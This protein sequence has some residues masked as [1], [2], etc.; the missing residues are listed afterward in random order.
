MLIKK[1]D[2]VLFIIFLLLIFSLINSIFILSGQ[3]LR[4]DEAQSIWASVKSIPAILLYVAQDVHVPLYELILHFWIQIF[5]ANILYA[6]I[7]SFIFFLGSLPFLYLITK[8]VINRNAAVLTVFLFSLS[9]FISWYTF[10]ARMYTLFTFLV[11]ASH[12]FFLQLLNSN[13]KKGSLGYFFATLAG[14]YTHYFFFLLLLTQ[15]LYLI[16]H[17]YEKFRETNNFKLFFQYYSG[18]LSGFLSPIFLAVFLFTP[19]IIYFIMLGSASNTQPFILPPSSITLFQTMVN[20]FFGL[21]DPVIQAVLVSLWPLA[22]VPLFF[23]FSKREKKIRFKYLAYFLTSSFL[24]IILVFIISFI[25]PI[26]LSRYLILV[27]P[28]LFMLF[29]WIL[30]NISFRASR[31]IIIIVA[32]V[33]FCSVLYQ[34]Q[35]AGTPVKEN[36]KAV[37]DYLNK[38]AQ[39]GDIIAVSPPFTVYPLMYYYTGHTRMTSI[40]EW[41]LYKIG[42]IQ[43]FTTA[44]MV[45]QINSYKSVDRNIYIVF[46]YDQ[47]YEKKIKQY[48]DNHYL[49]LIAKKFS[50]GLELRAYKLRY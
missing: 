49:R 46:S 2:L 39:P 43:K 7:L 44:N 28:S 26:F 32:F 29:A 27:T 21:Q 8:H 47:G 40:P 20:Y 48:M 50:P 37:T 15:C 13:G 17:F 42:P 11:C 3:S 30:E 12:Y 23:L 22:V 10:E 38:Q 36:Y 16:K 9:P 34:N 5:G 18:E 6:R 25:R 41:D 24:P 33:M 31:I 4:L 14:I 35:S 1:I 45:S 19:W